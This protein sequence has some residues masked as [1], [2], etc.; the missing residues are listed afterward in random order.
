[1]LNKHNSIFIMFTGEVKIFLFLF[2]SM[3]APKILAKYVKQV[4]DNTAL[5]LPGLTVLKLVVYANES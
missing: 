3:S 1:M 5:I 4:I 2:Y